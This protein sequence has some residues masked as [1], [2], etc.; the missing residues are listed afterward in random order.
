MEKKTSMTHEGEGESSLFCLQQIHHHTWESVRGTKT[1]GPCW[2][3][4]LKRGPSTAPLS[5]S[6]RCNGPGNPG[7]FIWQQEPQ[8]HYIFPFS[9]DSAGVFQTEWQEWTLAGETPINTVAPKK[10]N[11]INNSLKAAENFVTCSFRDT[12]H[13]KW[14]SRTVTY[15]FATALPPPVQKRP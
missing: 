2:F 5:T 1:P 6:L 4:P 10:G 7:A 14:S 3:W 15:N 8:G 11:A 12:V 9:A 13:T